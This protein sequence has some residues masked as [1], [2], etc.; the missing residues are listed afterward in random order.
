MPTIEAVYENKD[1][2]KALSSTNFIKLQCICTDIYDE[3]NMDFVAKD[4][5]LFCGFKQNY[6][7]SLVKDELTA[8]KMSNAVVALGSWF[9]PTG[10]T[11]PPVQGLQFNRFSAFRE[12][13]VQ[14]LGQMMEEDSLS[15]MP[16]IFSIIFRERSTAKITTLSKRGRLRICR[17]CIPR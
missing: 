1:L 8:L 13:V 7:A 9:E 16:E 2:T 15:A 10:S 12:T 11:D 6:T 14:R 3:I 5:A 4:M 17:R